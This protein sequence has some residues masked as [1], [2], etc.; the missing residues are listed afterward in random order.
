MWQ[1]AVAVVLTTLSINVF[2]GGLIADEVV[3]DARLPDAWKIIQ[4]S[5]LAAR[6]LN[7]EGQFSYVNGA[8]AR[9]VNIKHMNYGGREVARNIVLDNS[10][11]EVYSQGNDIVILQHMQ[12]NVLI[13]KRRG[14]NLFP[15]MLPTDLTSIKANYN[16]RIVATEYVANRMAQVVE[17]APK[18]VYR[19][20]Y[21][22]WTD[23][24]FGLILKMT[25][26]DGENKTLEQIYFNQLSMLN[27]ETL[28]WFQ[29]KFELGKNYVTEDV[30]P[31][32]RVENDLIVTTLPAGYQQIDHIQRVKGSS[33]IDQLVFSDGIGS[34][35]V[36]IEPMTKGKRPKT[37][38]MPMG[39]TNM[40]AHITD[41]HQIIVIGEVPAKAVKIIAEAVTFKK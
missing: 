4:K 8:N 15:A 36:F 5:A 14:K 34:V 31:S 9:T 28:N 35:S 11:R 21:K 12:N 24:K 25:L 30:N 26:L 41:G 1:L 29:P 7:Y 20:R 3:I 33:T 37:G 17:L 18:D 40:S 38:H 39:S 10:H 2:A 32:T 22:I 27:S 13:K 23:I 6:M 19:Y 16:A